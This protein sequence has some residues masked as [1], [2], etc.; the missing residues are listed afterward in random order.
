MTSFFPPARLARIA[1]IMVILT[2]CQGMQRGSEP[3]TGNITTLAT[4]TVV[5][6]KKIKLLVN[7]QTG[8][9]ANMSGRLVGT[10]SPSIIAEGTQ[11]LANAAGSLIDDRVHEEPG[12]QVRVRMDDAGGTLKQITQLAD[13]DHTFHVGDKVCI[14]TGSSPGNVFPD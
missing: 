13:P 8:A 6:V 9:F 7:N 2:G 1:A 14:S 5:R 12:V 3:P 11:N 4:G 10:I